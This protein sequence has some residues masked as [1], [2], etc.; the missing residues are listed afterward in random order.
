MVEL[1]SDEDVAFGVDEHQIV[2]GAFQDING[3]PMNVVGGQNTDEDVD[4]T[5]GEN[6]DEEG[7]SI[8]EVAQKSTGKSTDD[9][10][11]GD[12]EAAQKTAENEDLASGE[13]TDDEGDKTV[14]RSQE[15]ELSQNESESAYEDY[16]DPEWSLDDSFHSTFN[17]SMDLV[18]DAELAGCSTRRSTR[19]R[20]APKKLVYDELGQ[21]GWKSSFRIKQPKK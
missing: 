2:E 8:A 14:N 4:L 15:S 10:A 13:S 18:D 3:V 12:A 21:P 5:S 19:N 7:D 6:T 9:E 17:E 11:D 16:E 1:E 20:L